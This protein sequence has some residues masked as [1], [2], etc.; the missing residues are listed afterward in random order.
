MQAQLGDCTVDHTVEHLSWTLTCVLQIV[1]FL[2][3][4]VLM[5]T[6]IQCNIVFQKFA[7][8]CDIPSM[9]S[10]LIT[11]LFPFLFLFYLAGLIM[12]TYLWRKTGGREVGIEQIY[13]R[14]VR[15]T[16]IQ[17]RRERLFISLPMDS[18]T[19]SVGTSIFAIMPFARLVAKV[20]V[21]V[22]KPSKHISI[23][24]ERVSART[25]V[26]GPNWKG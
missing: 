2:F 12:V 4:F 19:H 16:Y 3:H 14:W 17:S 15:Y 24:N 6:T 1:P 5:D 8:E 13:R 9:L 7:C 23:S 22:W 25:E 11:S 21:S 20:K 18:L 10:I 26:W